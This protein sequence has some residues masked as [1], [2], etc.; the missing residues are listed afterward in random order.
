[1]NEI[2]AA[3]L[4]FLRALFDSTIDG[5]VARAAMLEA[6]PLVAKQPDAIAW[7]VAMGYAKPFHFVYENESPPDEPIAYQ[8]TDR[9][10]A[11]IAGE[12]LY[13]A[14]RASQKKRLTLEMIAT[15]LTKKLRR[16]ITIDVV[17]KRVKKLGTRE[18]DKLEA[19]LIKNPPR[20][21]PR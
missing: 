20:Q 19:D 1:M 3:A 5:D 16:S 12:R 11:L 17:K 2:P 8:L 18:H 14:K 4:Y 15:R 21:S 6:I 13:G 7:A 10:V 9:G